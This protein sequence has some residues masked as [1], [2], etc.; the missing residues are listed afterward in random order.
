MSEIANIVDELERAFEGNA[1][2]GPALNE[3]L[4]GVSAEKAAAR[5]LSRAHT[6]WE[7]VRHVIHWEEVVCKRLKGERVDKPEDG[8]WTE[9]DDV[10]P[11][12]WQTTLTNLREAHQTLVRQTTALGDA[13]LKEIAAGTD[14]TVYFMLHGVIQHNLYHGGQ[15]AL[16]KQ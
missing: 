14:Y 1:W 10:S 12:A 16:L 2:H 5:P 4:A 8:D 15:I 13:S 3:L 9:V 6:I 7:I 11:A